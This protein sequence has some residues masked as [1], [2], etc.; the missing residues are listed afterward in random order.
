MK[1]KEKRVGVHSIES[2]IKKNPHRMKKIVLPYYSDDARLHNWIALSAS[3]G[4]SVE[5]L[6][7]VKLEENV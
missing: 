5:V 4:I 1:N 7:K 6:K 2:I 3:N